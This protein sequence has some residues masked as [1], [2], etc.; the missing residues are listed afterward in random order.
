V[1]VT[2]WQKN[3][4]NH[5]YTNGDVQMMKRV[6][7]MSAAAVAAFSLFNVGVVE[8]LELPNYAQ[9]GNLEGEL[10]RKGQAV[11]DVITMIVAILAII[12]ILV[13]GGKIAVGDPQGGKQWLVGGIVALV[14]AGSVYG[15]AALV[16]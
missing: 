11:T 2:L 4:F 7:L 12:G 9:S 10:Q 14:I 8:A 1:P 13:G 15:I 5:C 16:V 6:V 3:I